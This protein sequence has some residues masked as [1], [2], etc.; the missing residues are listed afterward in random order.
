M[1]HT[2]GD[3]RRWRWRRSVLR[4]SRRRR[5]RRWCTFDGGSVDRSAFVG[6]VMLVLIVLMV[7]VFC[8]GVTSVAASRQTSH[9][10][11]RTRD[12]RKNI[13]LILLT[14]D[15]RCFQ[16]IQKTF[17]LISWRRRRFLLCKEMLRTRRWRRAT[18]T[19]TGNYRQRW[20]VLLLRMLLTGGTLELVFLHT[21]GGEHT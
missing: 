12:T 15:R 8:M 1:L 21:A 17:I 9:N 14:D 20:S 10:Q 4:G 18:G 5:W 19:C 16:F 2:R 7:V 6:I 3:R 13:L 11:R